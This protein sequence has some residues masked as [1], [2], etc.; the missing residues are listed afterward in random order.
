MDLTILPSQIGKGNLTKYYLVLSTVIGIIEKA[1]MALA[2]AP[3]SKAFKT[4][5]KMIQ[6]L[7]K[8]IKK[9]SAFRLFDFYHLKCGGFPSLQL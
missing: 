2:D 5:K 3:I 7:R 8:E 4:F 6:I 9:V 1:A